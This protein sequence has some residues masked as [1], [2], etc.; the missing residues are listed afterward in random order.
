MELYYVLEGTWGDKH[1]HQYTLLIFS[2]I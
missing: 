2:F 1:F